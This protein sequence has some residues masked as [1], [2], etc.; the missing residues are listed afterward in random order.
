MPVTVSVVTPSYNQARFLE[1]TLRSVVCQRDQVHEY[2]VLDGGSTDGSVDLIRKYER[3]IDHWESAKDKGQSDA[4]DRGFRR[5]TG[6]VLG[7]LNSDDVFLPGALARVREAFERHPEWDVVTGY[8]VSIDGDSRIL[9]L[10][11]GPRETLAKVRRGIIRVC[12]QTCFFRRKLYESIGGVNVSLHCVMD[13]DLWFRMFD[14]GATWGH[15][16]HF[17]AAFRW[18]SA[19]KTMSWDREYA[20]E[21]AWMA[22]KYPQYPTARD[23]E[24]L[25]RL[26]YQAGEVLSGRYPMA[27]LQTARVRGRKVTEVFGDWSCPAREASAIAAG[28][29]VR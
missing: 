2:F 8:H 4:I 10:H 3:D 26:V 21:R 27:R 23:G 29:D 6:D 18:H 13:H 17:Q 7:W 5:A 14:A 9:S 15:I 19:S 16:P 12:Q 24:P 1:E 11:R 22:E 28:H 20:A 25:A